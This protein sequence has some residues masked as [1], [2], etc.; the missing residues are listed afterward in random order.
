MFAG[1]YVALI[2]P[3]KD[4][5]IDEPRLRALIEY[6]IRNGTNGLVPCGTTGESA[7]LTE[8]EHERVIAIAI[9]TAA[10][11]VPVIA[12]TGTNDTAK[13]IRYTKAAERAGADGVLIVTPYYNKPTQQGLYLHYEAVARATNLPIILY[14]VPGRTSVNLLP[15]TVARLARIPNIVGIK[16]ASGNMDQV[17]QIIASCG[18]DFLVFSGDDSLTLPILALGGVGVISVVA[19]IAPRAMADLVAAYRAGDVARARRLH[20]ELFDLCRAMFLETNPIPVKTAA[21]ILGLCRDEMRLP[22]C[23]MSEANRQKL[24]AVLRACPHV[25]PAVPA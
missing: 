12:G 23:P 16:E 2:T 11:R 22:L 14:N 24:E 6:Q 8:E 15:E 25:Q 7:T 21:G 17:S 10:R 13:T 5:Q 4:G 1:S 18:P 9:E 19:N 3:F 20:Y